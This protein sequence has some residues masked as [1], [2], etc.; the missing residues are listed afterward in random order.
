[1]DGTISWDALE[2]VAEFVGVDD[3][4]ELVEG[5]MVISAHVSEMRAKQ[6]NRK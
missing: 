6:Q 4:E 3:L 1:M 2:H 5:L